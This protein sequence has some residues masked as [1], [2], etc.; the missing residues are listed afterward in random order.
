MYVYFAIGSLGAR[1]LGFLSCC[2][3]C[4]VLVLFLVIRRT[5]G[6]V[7]LVICVLYLSCSFLVQGVLLYELSHYLFVVFAVYYLG[8][9]CV[10][11]VVVVVILCSHNWVQLGWRGC[12]HSFVVIF[13]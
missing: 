9:Y 6:L 2:C 8:R 12:I 11:V 5:F 3:C 1:V 4:S 13:D 7:L 10:V